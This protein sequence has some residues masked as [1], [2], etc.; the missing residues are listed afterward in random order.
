M[1]IKPF[2]KCENRSNSQ[3]W[4]PVRTAVRT[5]LAVFTGDGNWLVRTAQHCKQPAKAVG[6]QWQRI[7]FMGCGKQNECRLFRLG[8]RQKQRG[9]CG[10]ASP[11]MMNSSRVQWQ[12]WGPF[13]TIRR[14]ESGFGHACV[15]LSSNA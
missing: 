8:K 4:C 9:G 7:I 3:I 13:L 6:G 14:K 15:S 10:L 1:K 5:C 11:L 2:S 12:G